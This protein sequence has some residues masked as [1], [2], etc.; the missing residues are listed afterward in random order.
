M[1]N[2]LFFTNA[3][4]KIVLLPSFCSVGEVGYLGHWTDDMV[5]HQPSPSIWDLDI[6]PFPDMGPGYPTL[7]CKNGT[8]IPY[9]LLQTSGGHH[10]RRVQTYPFVDLPPPPMV[11]TPS[12]NHQSTYSWQAGVT[13][14][15]G[16][17]SCVSYLCCVFHTQKDH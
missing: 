13:C 4:I 15:T 2:S 11:L 16:M 8:W 7:P 1:K 9:P 14:P 3:E 6:L 5:G 10:W 12:G 17:L